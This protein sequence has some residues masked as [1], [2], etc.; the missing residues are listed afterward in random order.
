MS[1]SAS[2]PHHQPQTEEVNAESVNDAQ[3]MRA[4]GVGAM[5]SD[6]LDGTS[7]GLGGTSVGFNC[8]IMGV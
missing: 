8:T 1:S 3:A 2:N 5:K 6:D 7:V 4:G